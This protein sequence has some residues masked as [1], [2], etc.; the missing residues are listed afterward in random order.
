MTHNQKRVLDFICARLK[1]NGVPPTYE[2]IRQEFGLASRGSV[3]AVV[4]R[5]VE[6]G[7]LLRRHGR[8]RSLA[9]PAIFLGDIPTDRLVAELERRGWRKAA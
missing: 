5:L 9:L 6:D 8:Q 3:H 7:H 2:E 1:A 4:G